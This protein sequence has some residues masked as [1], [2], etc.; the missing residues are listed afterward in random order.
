MKGLTP[1]PILF[2]P[3]SVEVQEG[4]GEKM[5]KAIGILIVSMLLLSGIAASA[6]DWVIQGFPNN[7]TAGSTYEAR[8]T[9]ESTPNIPTQI[10]LTISNSQ[11]NDTG[12]WLISITIDG[13]ETNCTEVIAGNF[14]TGECYIEAGLHD[15]NVSI[16]SL[17]NIL[18]DTYDITVEIWSSKILVDSTVL[19]GGGGGRDTTVTDTITPEPSP[20]PTISPTPTPTVTPTPTPIPPVSF[21]E[22]IMGRPGAM[23][24]PGFEAVFA[25]LGLLTMAYWRQRW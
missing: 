21:I 24:V 9:F 15:L 1:L 12:E 16:S 11:L 4:A 2:V 6:E 23:A 17:P 14:S 18:P 5:K 20:S 13:N 7:M 22:F 3:C 8:Y 19:V 10:N 25:I